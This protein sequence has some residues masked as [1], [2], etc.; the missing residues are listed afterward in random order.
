MHPPQ[1]LNQIRPA[2]S[3]DPSA[4]ADR[5]IS[6]R[7]K[8]Q[9]SVQSQMSTSDNPYQT[10][11]SQDR[12]VLPRSTTLFVRRATRFAVLG[13]ITGIGFGIAV[14]AVEMRHSLADRSFAEKSFT[15]DYISPIVAFGFWSVASGACLSIIGYVAGHIVDILHPATG[16]TIGEPSDGLESPN[17]GSTNG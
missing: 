9:T 11:S 5:C 6:R 16:Q 3:R 13:A 2:Q 14:F 1:V 10:S 8:E 15:I 12:R 17:S 4:F 7:S